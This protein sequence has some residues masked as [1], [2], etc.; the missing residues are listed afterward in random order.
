MTIKTELSVDGCAFNIALSG[1]V[2]ISQSLQMQDSISALPGSVE[3]VMIDL[4]QVTHLDASI[5]A[6]LLLLNQKKKDDG[7]SLEIN[8]C[9]RDFA[10]RFSLSGL[11]RFIKV[12]MS[13][14]SINEANGH[15]QLSDTQDGSTES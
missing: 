14:D 4:K 6:T 15:N 1:K 8:N 2:D 9:S 11:D 5:F 3:V 10:R 7:F 13:E 12:R